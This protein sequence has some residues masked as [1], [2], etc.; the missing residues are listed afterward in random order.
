MDMYNALHLQYVFRFFGFTVS[1]C[2][3]KPSLV[4]HSESNKYQAEGKLY[5]ADNGIWVDRNGSILV[6]PLK[7]RCLATAVWSKNNRYSCKYFPRIIE[8]KETAG[9]L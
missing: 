8:E 3:A 6:T 5:C 2:I 7:T 9:K 4:V 1:D